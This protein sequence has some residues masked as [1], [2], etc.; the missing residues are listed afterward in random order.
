L[1]SI[2]GLHKSLKIPP[3]MRQRLS[4]R[5]VKCTPGTDYL[6]YF[7]T[8]PGTVGTVHVTAVLIPGTVITDSGCAVPI[9]VVLNCMF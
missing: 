5:I 2:P 9:V 1:E 3:Q 6:Q 7:S 4:H 8:A